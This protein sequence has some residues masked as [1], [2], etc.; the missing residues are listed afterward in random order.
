MLS[1]SFSVQYTTYIHT[2][3]CFYYTSLKLTCIII[4]VFQGDPWMPVTIVTFGKHQCV[5]FSSQT[6]W[7][8]SQ[9]TVHTAKGVNSFV[10]HMISQQQLLVLFLLGLVCAM[11]SGESNRFM[12]FLLVVWSCFTAPTSNAN[13]MQNNFLSYII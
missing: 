4:Q 8:L 1:C 11:Q 2:Y 5:D 3:I 6:K 10:G 13:T 9:F 12:W 7:F